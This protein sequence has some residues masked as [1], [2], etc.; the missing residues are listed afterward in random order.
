MIM[1]SLASEEVEEEGV[2]EMEVSME[3]DLVLQIP[4]E[5]EKEE[6]EEEMVILNK[7]LPFSIVVNH[8]RVDVSKSLVRKVCEASTEHSAPLPCGNVTACRKVPQT[9]VKAELKIYLQATCK[10]NVITL[11]DLFAWFAKYPE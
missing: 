10:G 8:K 7:L 4:K 6:K 2:Q 9:A 3:S 1:A 5:E 11:D